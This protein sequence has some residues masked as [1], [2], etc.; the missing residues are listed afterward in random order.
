MTTR[1]VLI[2]G[3]L[4]T[5]ATRI[6]PAAAQVALGIRAGADYATISY[7]EP[8]PFQV[9]SSARPH[10]GALGSLSLSDLFQL[11]FEVA[12]SVKGFGIGGSGFDG[13]VHMTYLEF[14]LLAVVNVPTDW[15][16]APRLL[17]GGA[18]SREVSCKFDLLVGGA[19]TPDDCDAP[20]NDFES[21]RKTDLSLRF[22]GGVGMQ[23][24][25]WSTFADV[26]YDVGL[27]DLDDGAAAGDTAHSRTWI[28][29]AGVT[30]AVA[31]R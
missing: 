28:F 12:R 16:V 31:F 21:R 13:A 8:K 19:P 22:G 4:L 15:Q 18:V 23:F 10:I 25:P 26:L 5:A 3:I 20:E 24:G 6:D 1:H 2:A 11:Q 17:A 29:S 27:R 30:Y 9:E 14:P 7:G